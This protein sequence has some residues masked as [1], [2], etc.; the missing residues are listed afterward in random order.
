MCHLVPI[1]TGQANNGT[2]LLVL[3]RSASDGDG[4]YYAVIDAGTTVTN[5]D[6]MRYANGQLLSYTSANN[7]ASELVDPTYSSYGLPSM[8]FE[9]GYGTTRELAIEDLMSQIA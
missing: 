8:V 6:G 7:Y 9:S 5:S 3:V 2:T 4:R 1:L